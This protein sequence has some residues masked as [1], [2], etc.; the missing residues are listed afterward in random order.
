MGGRR[1]NWQRHGKIGEG[2]SFTIAG[3]DKTW[4]S[5]IPASS[6]AC[7]FDT[8]ANCASFF[9]PGRGFGAIFRVKIWLFLC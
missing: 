2:D 4:Q 3:K 1:E 9:R 6:K 7:S 5:E 8:Q